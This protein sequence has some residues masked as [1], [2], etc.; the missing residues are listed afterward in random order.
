ML[1]VDSPLQCMVRS[2]EP[3]MPLKDGPVELH[4]G[5]STFGV[6]FRLNLPRA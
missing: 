6:S 5:C 2:E 4:I 1:W 3:G